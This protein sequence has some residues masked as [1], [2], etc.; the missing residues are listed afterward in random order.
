MFI[1]T[2]IRIIMMSH[3]NARDG[4]CSWKILHWVDHLL[5]HKV[6]V[7]PAVVG[8]QARVEGEGDVEHVGLCVFP[9]K[10]FHLAWKM[11]NVEME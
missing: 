11:R 2:I 6:E 8:K 9:G 10:V 3:Q 1:M 7:V 5:D 4:N